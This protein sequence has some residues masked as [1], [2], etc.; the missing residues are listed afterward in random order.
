MGGQRG[1]AMSGRVLVAG[2]GPAGLVAAIALAR[3][4]AEVTL[5]EAGAFGRPKLC[6]EFLSPDAEDAL[7]A[8]GLAGLAERLGAP[9]IGAVRVTVARRGRRAAEASAPIVPGGHGVARADLDAALAGAARAAGADLRER[10]RVE[11]L[12]SGEPGVEARYGGGRVTADAALVATGRVPGVGA[13]PRRGSRRWVAVKTH[14]RGVSLPGVTELHFVRGAYAGLNEV[15][16]GGE[17][18][19]NVCALATRDAWE[20]AGASPAD[21]WELLARESPAFAERWRRARVVAG[22]EVSAAG[23]SFDVCAP[24][25]TGPRPVLRVGDAA[26]LIA[27]LAG[28]GQAMAALAGV[29]AAAILARSPGRLRDAGAVRDAAA[30][31]DARFRARFASR[32][33]VGRALQAALLRPAPA[34]WIVRSVAALRP[35]GPWVYRRTRGPLGPS[36]RASAPPSASTCAGSCAADSAIFRNP[37]SGAPK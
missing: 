31:W 30:E 9:A 36:A 32:L 3:A 7:A 25:G 6:G 33:R 20:R 35:L 4:G 17:R 19:V 37:P 10:C 18:V 2:G 13:A 23:F 21:F 12:E 14:V 16:C 27:P 1:A 5:C 15:A 11:S 26:A 24:A 34:A 28:D 22:S 8:V 29:E